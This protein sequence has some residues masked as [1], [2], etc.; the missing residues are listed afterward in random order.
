MNLVYIEWADAATTN[1]WTYKEDTGLMQV[2]SVGW[3]V[4][5]DKKTLTIA[6]SQSKGGKFLDPLTIPRH[7]ISHIGTVRKYP[8]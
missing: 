7:S 2:R 6:T 8:K 3:L 4:A 5:Q 1:G